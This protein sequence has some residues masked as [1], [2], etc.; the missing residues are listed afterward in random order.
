MSTL[1]KLRGGQA[2]RQIGTVPENQGT[3]DETE[4]GIG[5]PSRAFPP[6]PPELVDLTRRYEA[7][8]GTD[9]RLSY[10]ETDSLMNQALEYSQEDLLHPSV[11][12]AELLGEALA[13][14]VLGVN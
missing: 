13:T 3:V 11:A 14:E 9:P 2:G 4:I 10:L 1:T 12:G 7:L 8:A 5:W 6:T